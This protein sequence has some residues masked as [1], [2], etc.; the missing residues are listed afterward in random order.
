MSETI[1]PE[2]AET[3]NLDPDYDTY[4]MIVAQ[5]LSLIVSRV[6]NPHQYAVS[7]G[8]WKFLVDEPIF[9][10]IVWGIAPDQQHVYLID[11][12]AAS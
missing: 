11:G 6:T 7:P 12:I 3:C 9:G 4:K 5:T 8:G 10:S 2:K 1:V